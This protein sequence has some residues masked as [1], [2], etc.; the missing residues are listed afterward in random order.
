MTINKAQG[1]TLD[2]VGMYLPQ[3]VFNHSQLYIAM[4]RVR[5]FE[6]LKIQIIPNNKI[7]TM[8]RVY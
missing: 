5:S 4:F 6:K 8:N 1:Q 2:K 3:L 7:D